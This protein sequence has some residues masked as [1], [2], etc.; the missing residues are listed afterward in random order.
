MEIF[1]VEEWDYWAKMQTIGVG[2]VAILLIVVGLYKLFTLVAL[3]WFKA[4]KDNN[5]AKAE[6]DLDSYKAQEK[7]KLRKQEAETEALKVQTE[8]FSGVGQILE[9]TNS[10]LTEVLNR[11]SFLIKE[12]N[13]TKATVESILELIQEVKN[14]EKFKDSLPIFKKSLK[15]I[16]RGLERRGAL[17][18]DEIKTCVD[19]LEKDL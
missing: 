5:V 1:A 11:L 2:G 10:H 13:A 7:E 9:T 8:L 12:N 14:D 15:V 3:P 18:K 4:I 19:L 6:V 17:E 16:L